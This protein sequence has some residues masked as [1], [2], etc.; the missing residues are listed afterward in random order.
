M[1][2]YLKNFPYVSVNLFCR[3]LDIQADGFFVP[4]SAIIFDSASTDP[5]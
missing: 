5:P 4:I 3:R 1:E 2:V